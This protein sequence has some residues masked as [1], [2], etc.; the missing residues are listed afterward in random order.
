MN[1]EFYSLPTDVQ[2]AIRRVVNRARSEGGRR[3]EELPNGADVYAYPGRNGT[4]W[5]H[6]RASDGFCDARGTWPAGEQA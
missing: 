3:S 1:A 2:A 5:G 6:N 4:N